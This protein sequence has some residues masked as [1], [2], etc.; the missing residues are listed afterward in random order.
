MGPGFGLHRLIQ[1]SSY[2]NLLALDAPDIAKTV[3]AEAHKAH[4]LVASKSMF[5]RLEID[6][7]FGRPVHVVHALGY[8]NGNPTNFVDQFN[9]TMNIEYDEMIDRQLQK[10]ADRLHS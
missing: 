3:M 7:E 2:K 6:F 9:Q 8:F 1:N 5:S 10:L 4:G